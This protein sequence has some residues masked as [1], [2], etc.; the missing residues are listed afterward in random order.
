MFDIMIT[1]LPGAD[2]PQPLAPPAQSRSPAIRNVVLVHGDW[3]GGSNWHSVCCGLA[4]LGYSVSIAQTSCCS[5]AADIAATLQAIARQDGPTVLVGHCY[6]GSVISEAGNAANVA[7]LVYLAA[8][9]PDVGESVL[10]LLR[11]P[12]RLAPI[13]MATGAT[14]EAPFVGDALMGTVTEPAW[15]RKPSWYLLAE[16][17][18]VIP[19]PLQRHMAERARARISCV[20]G[21]HTLQLSH[22]R[23]VMEVID[24]AARGFDID[25][26]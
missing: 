18:N 11:T 17:D 24:H 2:A 16:E 19:P 21:N 5:L 4:A 12:P 23:S 13:A 25:V 6:G 7:A 26:S 14:K 8:F 1:P 3:S 10:D 22:P 9:I 20:V 15:Y